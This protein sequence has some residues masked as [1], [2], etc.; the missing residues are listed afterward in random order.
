VGSTI[1]FDSEHYV[2]QFAAA[3]DSPLYHKQ[4]TEVLEW[5]DV[6]MVASMYS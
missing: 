5:T 1:F 4:V 3:W 6:C 2:A